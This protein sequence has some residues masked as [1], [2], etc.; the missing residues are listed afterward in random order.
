MTPENRLKLA[1]AKALYC[2][3]HIETDHSEDEED[4]PPTNMEQE[5]IDAMKAF[6]AIAE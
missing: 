3:V 5:L 2:L 6:Q 4:T 1:T